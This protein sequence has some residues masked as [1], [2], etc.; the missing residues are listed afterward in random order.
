MIHELED[1][2]QQSEDYTRRI[3]EY[4]AKIFNSTF[5]GEVD[6]L[7][8][9]SDKEMSP[10]GMLLRELHELVEN[11]GAR[12][13]EAEAALQKIIEIRCVAKPEEMKTKMKRD[14]H[15]FLEI[16]VERDEK[17]RKSKEAAAHK[18]F[19]KGLKA[20]AHVQD[21][22]FWGTAQ[23][24]RSGKVVADFLGGLDPVFGVLLNVTG[25]EAFLL[26]SFISGFFCCRN[27]LLSP[28]S[29]S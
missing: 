19:G 27:L 24:L 21:E 3:E 17:I 7:E 28:A 5:T 11:E 12:T 22:S 26:L 14:Y 10:L 23:Q 13:S 4:L 15:R 25:E 20:I 9:Q 8:Q 16:K 6:H 1:S 2:D 18:W 29:W